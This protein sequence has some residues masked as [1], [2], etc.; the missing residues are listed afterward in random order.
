MSAQ[1][2]HPLPL[3]VKHLQD[4][5]IGQTAPGLEVGGQGAWPTQTR[6]WGIQERAEYTLIVP[7]MTTAQ[8]VEMEKFFRHVGSGFCSIVEQ[9]SMTHHELFCGPLA[10]GTRTTF[11]L[12]TKTPSDV[13]IFVDGVP[14]DSSTYTIHQAANLCTADDQADPDDGSEWST[15]N[16]TN[17]YV[18]QLSLVGKGSIR[19]TPNGNTLAQRRQW[20]VNSEAS[21]VVAGREYTAI[22]AMFEPSS[23][24]RETPLGFSWYVDSSTSSGWDAT[25]SW[26]LTGIWNIWSSTH[27]APATT[28]LALVRIG[29]SDPGAQTVPWYFDALSIAPGD[30]DRW[31]LPSQAPG[32][33]EFDTAPAAGSRITA[34][35]TGYRVARCRITEKPQWQ[36]DAAGR[37]TLKPLKAVEALEY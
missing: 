37:I 28:T 13:M 21:A 25:N 15:F 22:A 31:H 29:P 5:D 1:V 11:P 27:S 36:T 34:T 10:D 33:V 26:P 35:S 3:F 24:P 8:L 16:G 7:P 9:E 18:T 19:V 32:L 6:S 30:Y 2:I 4:S 14:Q 23:T 17:Q 12:P 20:K